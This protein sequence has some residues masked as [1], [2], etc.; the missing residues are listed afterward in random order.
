MNGNDR[1][2]DAVVGPN[3][4]GDI[5]MA[6]LAY[7]YAMEKKGENLWGKRASLFKRMYVNALCT[8]VGVA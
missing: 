8:L 5:W 2:E 7:V 4:S 1:Y 6:V 3:E